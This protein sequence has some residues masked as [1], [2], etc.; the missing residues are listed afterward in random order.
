M[1]TPQFMQPTFQAWN[2]LVAIPF[3]PVSSAYSWTITGAWIV[4]GAWALAAAVLAVAAAGRR[5]V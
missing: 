3:N 5:D 1:K 4:F 2:R